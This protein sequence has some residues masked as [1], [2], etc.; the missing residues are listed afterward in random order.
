MI[1]FQLGVTACIV[2]VAWMLTLG[3]EKTCAQTTH[4]FRGQNNDSWSDPFSWDTESVPN[5]PVDNAVIE[6]WNSGLTYQDLV[7]YDLSY[8]Q[9]REFVIGNT[10]SG[11]FV[12]GEGTVLDAEYTMIARHAGSTGSAAKHPSRGLG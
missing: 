7:Q 1:R 11:R 12:M 4:F 5:S 8:G 2:C 6:R 10:H 9:I 3:V